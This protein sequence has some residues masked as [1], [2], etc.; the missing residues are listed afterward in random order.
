MNKKIVGLLVCI[1]LIAVTILQ[2]LGNP[3]GFALG[4][5]T[6]ETRDVTPP[7]IT[8]NFAGNLHES[9]GPYWQPPG[10]STRLTGIFSNGY[11]INDS[12][13]YEDWIYINLTV[14]DDSNVDIV[15]L[16]WLNKTSWTNWKYQFTNTQGDF[17]EYNTNSNI[18]TFEGYKYSFNIVANDTSGNTNIVWWS[19]TGL[20]GDSTRRYV[21]LNCTT[22]D[23]SYT[24]YYLY[25]ATYGEE[26]LY[27]IAG[28]QFT[29]DR[30][31]HD[32][33]PGATLTDCGFLYDDIPTDTVEER[34]STHYVDFWFDETICAESFNLNNIYYHVWW[35]SDNENLSE[36]GW[37]K[38]R[39]D[40]DGIFTD[41]YSTD[42]S[43]NRSYST[44]YY[45]N[46][47]DDYNHNYALETRLLE[48]MPTAFTDNDIY[49]LSVKLE[50]APGFF[51][52]H[53]P[54]VISNRSFT[55]FVL[56]NVPDNDT[57][58][59]SYVD[60]D[61]DGLS[62]WT[63]LYK[64][65]T[66]PFLADTD[67]DGVSDYDE[68]LSGSDPNNWIDTSE[69]NNL[70]IAYND[71]YSTDEDTTLIV[72][73]PGVLENDTDSDGPNALTATLVDDVSNGTL[74]LNANGSFEYAPDVDWSGDDSFAYQAF[75][76][77][78]YSNVATV[79]ITVGAVNN[80]P[81]ANDDFYNTDEDTTLDVAEPG[82]LGNDED[83]DGPLALTVIL[84]DDV[85]NGTLTLNANGSF[86][87]VPNIEWTGNDTF[88]YRA[89][90]GLDDSNIATVTITVD[91]VNDPP[92][93][94]NDPDPSDGATDVSIDANLSWTG[95][96]PDPE[97]TVT[98]DVYFGT[99]SLPPQVEWNQSETI[100]NPELD[101][102]TTYYWKIVAWDNHGEYTEGP[103]WD[104]TTVEEPNNPPYV[105]SD[106]NPEDEAT[107]VSIN[108]DL[109]WTGGDS[110]PED[111]VTYD[112]YFGTTNPPPQVES[113][114]SSTFYNPGTLEYNTTYY[115]KIVS[116]DNH[117]AYA[118]GPI[119][120]FTTVETGQN[121]P[122]SIPIL[123]GL[124]LGGAGIEFN[125]TTVS[126]DPEGDQI[127]YNFSWGDGNFTG[128]LGSFNSSKNVTT[129]YSWINHG[130]YDIKVKAKDVNH[131]ESD[132]SEIH[133]MTIS[134]LI[135]INNLKLGFIYFRLHI[136]EKESYIYI[137]LLEQLG[138]SVVIGT[139]IFEI[140]TTATS[141]IVNSVKFTLYDP[142]WDENF[143]EEDDDSSD[144]FSAQIELITGI[145]EIT[146]SAYDSYGNLIDKDNI[147]S[148]I[149]IGV[150]E[151]E[152]KPLRPFS[153]MRERFNRI[154]ERRLINT[155]RLP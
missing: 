43:F 34:H 11:Y 7:T 6:G 86:V 78:D 49:E 22:A 46:G 149:N 3:I 127:Y 10:E 151:S 146:T 50:A 120:D 38:N 118:E 153:R 114:Q 143:T 115:W 1:S 18:K 106:P 40:A 70:P 105:P 60:S 108:A 99:T 104:F 29:Y 112:V 21:R 71:S 150:M 138:F 113:N 125:Y 128:W 14:T 24:P 123:T 62:D 103:T 4:N 93:S 9:G 59:A 68:Y 148:V 83:Y 91:L 13:Q 25:R 35:S 88:T 92:Y 95:G 45:D 5:D 39:D 109:S 139:E 44:I 63:E 61:S 129:N 145:Y 147:S 142:I 55:S 121:Q 122:P 80:P 57:L 37:H 154:R 77:L 19:K 132:W 64:T 42:T 131:E 82:I 117:S 144:G 84:V 98:Y 48:T 100:F 110:D 136:F 130:K 16:N 140:N 12:K 81:V 119:W 17:W 72:D 94:P 135:E 52:W 126:T 32:Q 54:S 30:L 58:N 97:D 73:T 74:T 51:D 56:F 111:I 66:S 28:S 26:D 76:G 134:K 47:D 133:T 27:Y 41:S 53:Y 90:D 15:W 152:E 96:D 141:D 107:D 87:Y 33:G 69:P 2:V 116:W 8:I 67:N 20:G 137:H 89:Y 23:T 124:T 79:T 85:L 155:N 31:H 75:D 36:V 101:Y 65:Y 102:N